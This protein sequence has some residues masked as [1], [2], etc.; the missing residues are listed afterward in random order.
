MPSAR[1]IPPALA[2]LAA[3]IVAGWS[4]TRMSVPSHSEVDAFMSAVLPR[5]YDGYL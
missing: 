2:V 3:A 5:E 4:P 1:S